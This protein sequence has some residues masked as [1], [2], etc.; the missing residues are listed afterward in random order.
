[1]V[2]SGLVIHLN[3]D[4]AAVAKGI[5]AVAGHPAFELGHRIGNVLPAVLDASGP[6]E[7]HELTEWALGLPGVVH[8]DV[9]FVNFEEFD[10]CTA[11]EH[12]I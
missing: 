7:T 3:G 11:G 2:I 1:V 10:A 5:E 8:I 6:V 12:G 4:A 9:A